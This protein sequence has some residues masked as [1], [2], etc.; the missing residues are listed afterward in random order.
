MS[1]LAELL[2][3][4]VLIT[5]DNEGVAS[6][7]AKYLREHRDKLQEYVVKYVIRENK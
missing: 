1:L 3:A 2:E 7:H 4:Y 6:D 5:A